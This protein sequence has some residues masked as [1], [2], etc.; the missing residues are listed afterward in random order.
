[1]DDAPKDD[2]VLLQQNIFM[3]EIFIFHTNR[4]DDPKGFELGGG[5]MIIVRFKDIFFFFLDR[6]GLLN[7]RRLISGSLLALVPFDGFYRLFSLQLDLH[8]PSILFHVVGGGR[9]HDSWLNRSDQ[10]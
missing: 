7:H 10:K 8:Q 6:Q 5:E 3:G 2:D 1:M 9:R 4:F